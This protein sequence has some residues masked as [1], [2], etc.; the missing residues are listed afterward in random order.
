VSFL[1]EAHDWEVDVFAS[2]LQ[3]LH[4][5]NVTKGSGDKLMWISSE[6]GVFKV[7]SFCSLAFSKGSRFPW[8]SVW[9][10]PAPSRATFFVWLAALGKILTLDNFK[11]R[12]VIVMDKCCMCK[13]NGESVDHLLHYD[14]ASAI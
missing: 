11:K 4:S 3:L 5:V 9:R 14:V 12:H 1:R 8:K 7:K 13:R 2:F 10:T 6:R